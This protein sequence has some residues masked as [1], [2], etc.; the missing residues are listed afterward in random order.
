[1]DLQDTAYDPLPQFPETPQEEDRVVWQ[2]SQY[3]IRDLLSQLDQCTATPSAAG[4]SIPGSLGTARESTSTSTS[5]DSG[6]PSKRPRR[7]VRTHSQTSL[8]SMGMGMSNAHAHPA[9][10][11][12]VGAPAA[13]VGAEEGT[14]AQDLLLG[15]INRVMAQNSRKA[16]SQRRSREPREQTQ[17]GQEKGKEPLRDR[18]NFSLSTA[19]PSPRGIVG[20]AKSQSRER[21]V[22]E[23]GERRPRG[24]KRPFSH[25]LDV[26]EHPQP[27]P[28]ELRLEEPTQPQE[29]MEMELRSPP[30]TRARA[31]TAALAGTPARPLP[32]PEP[33][34]GSPEHAEHNLPRYSPGAGGVS[35]H[36]PPSFAPSGSQPSASQA[37]AQHV[38]KY[39][40]PLG[41]HVQRKPAVPLFP[42]PAA[43]STHTTPRPTTTRTTTTTVAAAATSSSKPSS[44]KPPSRTPSTTRPKP[45]KIPAFRPPAPLPLAHQ[46]QTQTPGRLL[47]TPARGT[48]AG[49]T[50]S[51][52]RRRSG[53]DLSSTDD[54]FGL[55]LAGVDVGELEEVMRMYDA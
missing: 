38:R 48:V 10:A 14:Q 7:P 16:A 44:P 29:E 27:Q 32:P 30:R 20:G 51:A 31:R 13:G 19:N 35:E 26:P 54:S 28:P 46:T 18:T 17:K 12:S 22:V 52:S 23:G 24:T 40:A 34:A 37:Q 21:E 42:P 8:A 39:N 2:S 25:L 1:M 47:L 55:G 49:N 36:A 33:A 15:M 3:A 5:G 43:R 4:T 6:R 41:M 53:A 45:H 9:T 11:P 50:R